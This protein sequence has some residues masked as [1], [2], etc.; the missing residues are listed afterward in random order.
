[1]SSTPFAT[2]PFPCI[3]CNQTVTHRIVCGSDYYPTCRQCTVKITSKYLRNNPGDSH[4]ADSCRRVLEML[5]IELP[6]PRAE[7]DKLL[8]LDK[9]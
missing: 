6:A 2:G 5:G 8:L 3:E 4:T 9:A 7:T 1:M